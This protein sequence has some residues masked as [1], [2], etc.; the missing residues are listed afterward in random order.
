[1]D[2]SRDIDVHSIK[3]Y[4]DHFSL[5]FCGSSTEDAILVVPIT[6]TV[7]RE[8]RRFERELC[9]LCIRRSVHFLEMH[10]RS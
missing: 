2:A 1:M 9:R 6:V 5:R 7:R 10:E 4:R 8:T 3:L